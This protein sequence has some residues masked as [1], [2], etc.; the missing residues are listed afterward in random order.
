MIDLNVRALTELS[1]TFVDSLARHRGGIL[2]V[3]SVAAFMPGPGMAVYYASKAYVLSFSEALHQEFGRRGIRVTVP[4]TSRIRKK[5]ARSSTSTPAR[6]VLRSILQ[7]LRAPRFSASSSQAQTCSSEESLARISRC[8]R[9]RLRGAACAESATHRHFDH[10][11]RANR[12]V[13]RLERYRSHRVRDGFSPAIAPRVSMMPSARI[14]CA[15]RDIRPRWWARRRRRFF[16]VGGLTSRHHPRGSMDRRAMLAG[17][18]STSKLEMAAYTYVGIPFSRLRLNSASGLE[19]MRCRDGYIYT[20]WAADAHYKALKDLLHN[21][22]ELESEVFDKASGRQQNDDVLRPLIR[23]HLIQYT[24]GVPGQRRAA[25]GPDDWSGV[26]SRTGGASST[27]A[28]ARGVRRNRIIRS[29]AAS[30][31]RARW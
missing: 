17:D 7:R 25:A 1:L 19:P 29:R 28:R 20:L 11:V 21:S 18:R 10:A 13:S 12:A 30:N 3:A 9:S 23:E 24:S 27:P 8:D 31:I 16:D 14:R 6:R 5:A 2:N 26:H 15:R 4:A 22:E